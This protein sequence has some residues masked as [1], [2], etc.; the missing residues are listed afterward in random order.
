MYETTDFRCGNL[1]RK[2][3]VGLLKWFGGEKRLLANPELG[4]SWESSKILRS[5]LISEILALLNSMED[6]D[7]NFLNGYSA[8]G[9]EHTEDQK[10]QDPTCQGRR[11]DLSLERYDIPISVSLCLSLF[12]CLLL[13][14]SLSLFMHTQNSNKYVV[15]ICN[16]IAGEVETGGCLWFNGQAVQPNQWAPG[17]SFS[18]KRKGVAPEYSRLL[19]GFCMYAHSYRLVPSWHRSNQH[20]GL[21]KNSIL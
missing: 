4:R 14:L 7:R 12:L 1:C 17:S 15:N 21:A 9:Q 18:H 2:L 10:Q 5:W 13:S 20:H 11:K 6:S 19:C 3:T 16:P 8:T